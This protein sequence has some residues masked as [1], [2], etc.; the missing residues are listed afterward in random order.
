PMLKSTVIKVPHHGSDEGEEEDYLFQAVSARLAV[1]SVDRDNR[2][3]LPAPEV[4]ERLEQLG[5]RV[6]KTGDSGAV[7]IS[8]DGR[9]V[10]VE[11]SDIFRLWN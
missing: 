4:V 7:I 1:I 5:A 9:D 3:G 11:T 8:T 10:Q 2:L 6:Y